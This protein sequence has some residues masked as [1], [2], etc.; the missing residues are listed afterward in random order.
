[1]TN[2]IIQEL[3][4]KV[5]FAESQTEQAFAAGYALRTAASKQLEAANEFYAIENT[6]RDQ[7]AKAV[8]DAR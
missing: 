4:L 7:L 3:R 5:S 8:A 2:T 6:L 1:M